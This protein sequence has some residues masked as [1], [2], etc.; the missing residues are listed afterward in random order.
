MLDWL[1]IVISK[2]DFWRGIIYIVTAAGVTLAPD[3]Q[4]A[5]ITAGLGLSGLFHVFTE[6]RRAK[7]KPSD[8]GNIAPPK[9]E[10]T[11]PNP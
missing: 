3:Q 6:S 11:K 1:L 4:T 2:P 10:E 9:P 5:I 7:D 8:P